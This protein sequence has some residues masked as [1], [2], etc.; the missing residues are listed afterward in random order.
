MAI[1]L[2][3]PNPILYQYNTTTKG[4]T[5][6]L[7]QWLHQKKMV[8]K[9][10]I[11][12]YL[13]IFAVCCLTY[14]NLYVAFH[15]VTSDD[16]E[17]DLLISSPTPGTPEQREYLSQSKLLLDLDLDSSVRAS[18]RTSRECRLQW[19]LEKKVN[20]T[21]TWL[22]MQLPILISAIRDDRG[23]KSHSNNISAQT[24]QRRL[25]RSGKRQKRRQGNKKKDFYQNT[26]EDIVYITLTQAHCRQ[27]RKVFDFK[28]IPW[29][30]I[31]GRKSTIGKTSR[32]IDGKDDD[33]RQELAAFIPQDKPEAIIN[34]LCNSTMDDSFVLKGIYPTLLPDP[35][36]GKNGTNNEQPF[37][38]N[39]E[40]PLECDRLE[41]Q[42]T[43]KI[44]EEKKFGACLRFKGEFDRSLVPQWIE[45][46]RILGIEHFWVYV[47]EVWDL[48]ALYN[49]SYITY[50]P[51]D[52]NWNNHKSHFQH[53]YNSY[54][55]KISQE[56]ASFACMWNAKKYGYDWVTTIDVDE[57]IRVPAAEDNRTGVSK[58]FPLRSY[59]ERFD[60]NEYSCF[61]MRS[62]AFGRN[63]WLKQPDYPINPLLID[64]VWRQ[65]KNLSEYSGHRAKGIYNPQSV[66]SFGVHYCWVVEG[67]I[68]GFYPQKGGLFMHHYKLA[69]EGVY[70]KYE[71]KM[72][73][74]EGDLLQ[75]PAVRDMY[76]SDLAS[77]LETL[78]STPS[79]TLVP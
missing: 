48:S 34:L 56:P 63:I 40:A 67:T 28:K 8:S 17:L 20:L 18:S 52:L 35:I 74:S 72:V 77:A 65:N 44:H 49:Q 1:A 47:N 43:A 53:R 16:Y 71:K 69:H 21:N 13:F 27:R 11:V 33:V 60:P 50:V 36:D 30:C 23:E 38:Y 15:S 58:S 22:E 79:T 54:K 76:R 62:I 59:M 39:L 6:A 14:Q 45:Y 7:M 61:I 19:D 5:A 37:V 32:I 51:Y 4:S 12:V 24:T 57:W 64:Y 25:K 70:R 9:H 2:V 55:P 26:K 46:H 3:V 73:E 29:T 66:W 42:E 78:D 10:N 31:Y 41:E 68:N 75:D